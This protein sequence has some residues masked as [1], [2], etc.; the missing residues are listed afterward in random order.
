MS[1]KAI[2]N[3]YSARMQYFKVMHFCVF[4][5]L[6]YICLLPVY[7]ISDKDQG[8]KRK[9]WAGGQKPSFFGEKNRRGELRFQAGKESKKF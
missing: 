2:G 9:S 6:F 3:T 1:A 8:I 4:T 5:D 7:E